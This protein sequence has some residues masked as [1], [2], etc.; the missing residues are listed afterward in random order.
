MDAGARGEWAELAGVVPS[1]GAPLHVGLSSIRKAVGWARRSGE[2]AFP[3]ALVAG[4][5]LQAFALS[6]RCAAGSPVAQASGRMSSLTSQSVSPLLRLAE[7]PPA[8]AFSQPGA[9]REPQPFALGDSLRRPF[10]EQAELGKEFFSGQGCRPVGFPFD[11]V[12]GWRV[13]TVCRWALG[14]CRAPGRISA[15]NGVAG[16][17]G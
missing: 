2:S 5:D 10:V 15:I 14:L 12:L 11:C 6:R 17:T 16:V 9:P 8:R 4:L 3:S 1:H 13:A 7:F